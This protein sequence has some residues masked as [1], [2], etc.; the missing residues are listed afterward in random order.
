MISLRFGG[1]A[2]GGQKLSRKP[3]D[4]RITPYR[5]LWIGLGYLAIG[6]GT[7]G[8]FLPIL[9]TTPFA[10]LAA[11]CFSKGSPRLHQWLRAHPRFGPYIRNWEAHRV[12]PLH[13]KIIAT[14]VA[15]ISIGM[16]LYS[17][18]MASWIKGLLGLTVIAVFI[19]IWTR[20]SRASVRY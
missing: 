10:L 14:A 6:F 1:I 20:P 17:A 11:F 4:N 13:A 2:E 16:V 9:P 12:I 8:L 3:M 7:A 15:G 19:W 18:D 5:L